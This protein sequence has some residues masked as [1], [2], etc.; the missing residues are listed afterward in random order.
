TYCN[1]IPFFFYVNPN[2]FKKFSSFCILYLL[3]HGEEYIFTLPCAYA[4]S[5]LTI[6]WVELGGKVNIHCAKSGYSAT[7]T[8]H[9]KPFYGGKLHRV[10][11]EVKHNPTNTVVCK[12]QGEWNGI[13]EFSYSNGETKVIDTTKLPTIRKKIRP[14]SKQGPFESRHLWQHVTA[15]LKEGDIDVATEHKH[16]LEERQRKE[17]RQRATTNTLWKPK[18]FIKE[19]MGKIIGNRNVQS[20]HLNIFMTFQF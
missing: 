6:P 14:I 9:T 5:I 12:A 2:A 16:V 8:F 11:A 17:E 4:R 3:E 7:V 15:A 13:L 18:Y 1:V 19:V 10:T 20:L